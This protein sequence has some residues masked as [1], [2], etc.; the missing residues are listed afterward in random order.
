[1]SRR[2]DAL[3]YHARGRPGKLAIRPTKPLQTQRDLSL[4][5]SPGVAEPC[6]EIA[7]DKETVFDYTARGNLVAVVSNGTA[8]LGLGDIGPEAGKP[9]MEGKGV[10]FKRFADIDVFDL[11]L[12]C[13]DP[14]RFVDVVAALAPTF[15][16]INLEDIAA[17]DCFY[18]EETLRERLD[19]P[20]FHDDQHGT[21][22]IAAAA[23]VN[24]LELVGKKAED[25]RC[26]F[27]GAGAAAIACA[28]LFL[29]LGVRRE[30]VTLCDSRGVIYTGRTQGMNPYK[31]RFARE[32]DARS[33]EDALRDADVFVGVSVKG[34]VTQDMLRGMARDPIVMA[35]ANPDPEISYPDAKAARDDVIMATGRSD[36]PN[37]VNNVL[38]FPFIFRGALDVRA[39]AINEEMKLAAVHAL[40]RLAKEEVP[41]DVRRA[42]GDAQLKFG[43]EYIIPKPFDW[44]ALL[45]LAPAVARAAMES[46]VARK[47][48]DDWDAYR[49]RLERILGRER[50][51]MRS[52][53]VKASRDPKR[54]VFPEAEHPKI[55]RAAQQCVEEGIAQPILI[56]DVTKLRALAAESDIDLD[57]ITLIDN[58]VDAHLDR[59]VEEYYQRRNRRGV[60]REEAR[61]I[62]RRRNHYAAMMVELG[63]ADGMISGMTRSY[64][65]TVRPALEIIGPRP[66]VRR[67]A[68]AYLVILEDGVKVFAD[69][70]VNIDPSAE[71]L[72]EIAIATATMAR[73]LDIEPHVA[74]LSFSNFGS[75]S[76]PQADKVRRAVAI[77]RE[78]AP[79]LDVD[80]EMQVG[81]ALDL[82]QRKRL[83]DFC[84]LDGEANVLVFPELNSANIGYKL[85]G[86][87][88]NAELVGP[89]LIGMN[90]P[91]NV[92]ERD[93]SVRAVVNMAAIT[94]VQA[95]QMGRAH[96]GR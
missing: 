62:L 74:M 85:M 51:V 32:T 82:D 77:L 19:I 27:S 10:L 47:P 76:S 68:G 22:I 44:R 35:M 31:E 26:V 33:L 61:R 96:T 55:M 63:D 66:G 4:A 38:G 1:M 91:A 80:G 67:V 88:G 24:A 48:I 40:A 75:N 70:T 11:E 83:F 94:V 89:V 84:T 87:L 9:V 20:V 59:Y 53:I 92:L 3:E 36:Y 29:S 25:V 13:K 58:F 18:I 21:A 93:C 64:P 46:G 81:P 6:L 50:E 17:P 54:L 37:Q 69:T 43:P 42:Y 41:E 28:Q 71:E 78:R 73:R 90:R 60:T 95:Q 12:D 39:T 8:V 57:G 49:N 86:Q 23:F 79:D 15:G 16:G 30:N 72:A 7:R 56:G 65:E 14:E 52:I 34:V 45:R 5:Y 2:R